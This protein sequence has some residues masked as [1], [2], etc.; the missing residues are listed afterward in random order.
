MAQMTPFLGPA[1]GTDHDLVGNYS[2][3]P[4]KP[5]FNGALEK[6][7]HTRKRDIMNAWSVR[8]DDGTELTGEFVSMLLEK[9]TTRATGTSQ[10][11][12]SVH[13]VNNG[14]NVV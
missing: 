13:P 6:L 7:H 12:T 3:Q 5:Q 8:A 10:S 1:D 11:N 2:S 4:Y 9:Y 14:G